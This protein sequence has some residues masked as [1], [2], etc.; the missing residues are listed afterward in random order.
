MSL[1]HKRE[2]EICAH[3]REPATHE[4]GDQYDAEAASEHAASKRT[5]RKQLGA[6][7]Q[8]AAKRNSAKKMLTASDGCVLRVARQLRAVR[9]HRVQRAL[10][11]Q[12]RRGRACERQQ[13]TSAKSRAI[14]KRTCKAE[15]ATQ[16][17]YEGQSAWANPRTGFNRILSSDNRTPHRNTREGPRPHS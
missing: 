11:Q 17:E 8:A 13:G 14:G 2:L 4:T 7:A 1:G 3:G 9:E 15:H 5:R 16:A 12:R 6:D 10:E